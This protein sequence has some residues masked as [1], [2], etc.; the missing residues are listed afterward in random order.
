MAIKIGFYDT[1]SYDRNVF[2]AHNKDY[3]FEIHYFH[4]RL[5]ME[6]V[7]L[8]KGMDAVCIFVDDTCDAR[9]VRALHENG[10]KLIALRCA[11]FNNVDLSEA[12]GKLR[13]ARVPAYSPYAVA[14]YAMTLMLCLN[15]KVYRS[16]NRTREFNFKLNGLMG[17]DMHEKT[18]GLIGLGRIAKVLVNIL[19]GFG[20]HIL[21]YDPY[22]DKEFAEIN[23]VELV[24]LDELYKR[25]DIISLHTPLTPSSRF[26]INRVS[27]NKMKPG[28][29]LINTSRGQLIHTEDLIIGLRSGQIGSAGLDVYEYEQKYFYEDW[30]EQMVSDDKLAIL[31][32]MPNVILTSHQAFFTREALENI[33]TTTLDNVK[34]FFERG[35]LPNEVN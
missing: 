18:V 4:N 29:M 13:V 32:S 35:E 24:D 20:M 30:S 26:M 27:I 11:G 22:P 2:D 14:E 6:T 7:G 31:L 12:K 34:T 5:N 28:V 21:A 8:S 16:V 9:V 3:G 17:F 25:S 1:K 33:A 23:G 19:K 10:V 15:R